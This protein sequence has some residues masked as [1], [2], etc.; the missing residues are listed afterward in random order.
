[1]R[2]ERKTIFFMGIVCKSYF[3]LSI[4]F[5][6]PFSSCCKFGEVC[7][8]GHFLKYMKQKPFFSWN[9][10]AQKDLSWRLR[11]WMLYRFGVSANSKSS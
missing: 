2:R 8:E 5:P 6:L 10:L 11:P 9:A 4:P 7:E 1:M 3:F